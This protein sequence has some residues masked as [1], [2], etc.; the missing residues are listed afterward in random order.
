[1]LGGHDRTERLL[2]EGLDAFMR[3]S[4]R[5]LVATG[6]CSIAALASSLAAE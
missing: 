6:V 2:G 4:R 3:K 5:R 1:M